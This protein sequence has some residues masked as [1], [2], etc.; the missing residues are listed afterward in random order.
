MYSLIKRYSD[1]Y[2]IIGKVGDDVESLKSFLFQ[3][4][5]EFV[6][7]SV[8]FIEEVCGYEYL[9]K[10]MKN[11]F[12]LKQT[13]VVI[14]GRKLKRK[15]DKTVYIDIDEA[16]SEEV[17]AAAR[18]AVIQN[19]DFGAVEESNQSDFLSELMCFTD[20]EH[21][22]VLSD[23][24]FSSFLNSN[25]SDVREF[26]KDVVSNRVRDTERISRL[27]S[28]VDSLKLDNSLME[29]SIRNKDEN[30]K[31]LTSKLVRWRD[32]YD[33]LTSLIKGRTGVSMNPLESL[34]SPGSKTVI[35]FKEVSKVSYFDTFIKQLKRNLN[36]KGV[37]TSIIII[38]PFYN[39]RLSK[40]YVEDGYVSSESITKSDI[41]SKDVVV[42][43]YDRS[44]IQ[45]Y[46]NHTAASNIILVDKSGI[47]TLL[48]DGDNVMVLGV[49]SDMRDNVFNFEKDNII[50]YSGELSIP[51]IESYE[52][53]TEN[54]RYAQ[55]NQLSIMRCMLNK[56]G[57]E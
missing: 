16:A 41:V 56:I 53:M 8:S 35:Y 37:L 55:Y 1:L 31:E 28:K 38:L 12:Q 51:T 36:A 48:V 34:N 29:E 10:L 14:F 15:P 43:G 49:M 7:I 47:D 33:A 25:I 45:A 4:D 40:V 6:L 26:L 11:Y 39:N 50:S 27:E 3:D 21:N 24:L 23:I 9:S 57:G 5:I 19:K 22:I 42:T 32:K 2:K 18:A 13:K 20:V 46:L 30:I 54:S 44:I 52:D 17:V